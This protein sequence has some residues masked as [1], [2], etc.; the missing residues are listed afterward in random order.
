VKYVKLDGAVYE[1]RL[2]EQDDWREAFAANVRAVGKQEK[3]LF[4]HIVIDHNSAPGRAFAQACED[5]ED[6]LFYI[7]LPGWFK[8]ET[9]VGTYNPDWAVAYRN[10]AMLYFVAETKKTGGGDHVQLGLLRP[11]EDLRIECG[12][13]HFQNFE[14]VR[15]KVVSVFEELLN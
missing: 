12:K 6:V 9:P 1:M 11:I 10:D 5:N 13:R 8:I 4:S 15:F 7:K 14:Q 3:T 2:F